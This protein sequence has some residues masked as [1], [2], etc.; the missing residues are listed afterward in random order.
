[1]IDQDFPVESNNQAIAALLKDA[2]PQQVRWVLVRSCVGSDAK[3]ARQCELDPT[4]VC[5]W[6]NKKQLDE[7]VHLLLMDSVTHAKFILRDA[8]PQAAQT[9]VKLLTSRQ[10]LGAADSVL[11]RVGVQAVK[12][13]DVTTGGQDFV[14]FLKEVL[15]DTNAR[16][17]S[18]SPAV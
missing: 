17:G 11:D 15:I 18:A 7:A 8:A 1:M 2:S 14:S 6:P 13:V 16:G 3:A 10:A 9:L 12:G 5:K 4:T